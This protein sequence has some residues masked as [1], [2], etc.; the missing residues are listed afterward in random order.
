MLRLECWI[1]WD[2][3]LET[4]A[5]EAWHAID[6]RTLPKNFLY[7]RKNRQCANLDQKQHITSPKP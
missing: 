4:E 5:N 3:I 1:R 2:N 7:T 6:P